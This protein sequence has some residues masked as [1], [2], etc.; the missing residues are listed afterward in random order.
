MPG[1]PVELIDELLDQAHWRVR[2]HHS[3]AIEPLEIGHPK[4]RAQHGLSVACELLI[5]A[6]A[7]RKGVLVQ[8]NQSAATSAVHALSGG[9]GDCEQTRYRADV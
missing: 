8:A 4:A 2:M 5:N 1:T 9:A 6:H 7:R 3:A